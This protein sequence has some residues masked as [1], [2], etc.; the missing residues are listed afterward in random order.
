M[1]KDN[2]SFGFPIFFF[3]LRA[4]VRW[5]V[6][7]MRYTPEPL[8]VGARN[9][10]AWSASAIEPTW[11]FGRQFDPTLCL[12]LCSLFFFFLLLKAVNQGLSFANHFSNKLKFDSFFLKSTLAFVAARLPKRDETLWKDGPLGW[13]KVNLIFVPYIIRHSDTAYLNNGVFTRSG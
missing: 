3:F 12:L 8:F 5:I 2:K 10:I 1:C 13:T 9:S 4:I 11:G 7:G 6:V